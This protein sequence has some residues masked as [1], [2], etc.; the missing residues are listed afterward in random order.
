MTFRVS[1]YMENDDHSVNMFWYS[2]VRFVLYSLLVHLIAS[3][4]GQA[5][6]DGGASNS[7]H[8]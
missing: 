8:G 1:L 6:T 2:I 4:L 5:S 7:I 3:L